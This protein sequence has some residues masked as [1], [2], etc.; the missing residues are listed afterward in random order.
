MSDKRLTQ[1]WK[2]GVDDYLVRDGGP[3]TDRPKAVITAGLFPPETRAETIHE[4]RR[5]ACL[6]TLHE[7]SPST[8]LGCNATMD[9]LRFSDHAS[10]HAGFRVAHT[11][12]GKPLLHWPA[13]L[14]PG[15]A[16]T[17][18]RLFANP[19]IQF[20]ERRPWHPFRA[21]GI[22]FRDIQSLSKKMRVTGMAVRT[23]HRPVQGP[24]PPGTTPAKAPLLPAP[25]GRPPTRTTDNPPNTPDAAAA[26]HAP[27]LNR[28]ALR[29]ARHGQTEQLD[30]HSPSRGSFNIFFDPA[31]I[32]SSYMGE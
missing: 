3:L 10:V 13:S 25:P 1:S 15:C 5:L 6:R 2:E 16:S 9:C 7:A 27:P 28:P 14:T 24:T 21:C 31:S 4:P 11:L 8:T 26:S 29:P 32:K 23:T 12:Q 22:K 30:S 18:S 19:V 17:P 20:V